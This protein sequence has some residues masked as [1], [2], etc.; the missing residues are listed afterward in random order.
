MLIFKSD[1]RN[2]VDEIKIKLSAK[3]LYPMKSIK[4]LEIKIDKNLI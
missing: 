4:Y 3:R 2:L 1:L